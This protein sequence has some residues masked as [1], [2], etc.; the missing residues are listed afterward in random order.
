LPNPETALSLIT[1][2]GIRIIAQ[3]GNRIIITQL[4]GRKHV[5]NVNAHV[6]VQAQAGNR[7]SS[8]AGSRLS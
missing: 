2:P 7:L 8:A 5:V 3:P 1:Q 6:Q 4:L